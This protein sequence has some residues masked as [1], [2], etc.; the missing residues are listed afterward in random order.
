MIIPAGAVNARD[1]FIRYFLKLF[2]GR[3]FDHVWLS[4]GATV[5]DAPLLA[6]TRRALFYTKVIEQ[7][8]PE[9]ALECVSRASF[10][11]T[12]RYHGL[13]F[14]RISGVPYYVPQDSPYKVLSEDLSA[15]PS[16]AAGHFEVLRN[17]VASL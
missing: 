12:G 9:E 5:D 15:D 7:P 13:I 2:D 3:Q 14:A 10:V 6:D 1:P 16:T 4:M 11:M 8:T 17:A